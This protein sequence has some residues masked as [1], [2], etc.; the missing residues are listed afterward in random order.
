MIVQLVIVDLYLLDGAAALANVCR[1]R[2][3]SWRQISKPMSRLL[4]VTTII[5]LVALYTRSL[6]KSLPNAFAICAV[7]AQC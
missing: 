6:L 2:P 5:G 4:A 3:A 1:Q 7:S